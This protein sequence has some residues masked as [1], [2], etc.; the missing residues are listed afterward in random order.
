MSDSYYRSTDWRL[1]RKIIKARDPLCVAPGCGRATAHVDH[2]KPRSEGGSDDP[3]NLRGLCHSCHNSR[4]ARGNG[5]V[6]AIGCNADGTPRDI[7]DPW[8]AWGRPLP[9]KN[10]SAS[11]GSDRGGIAELSKFRNGRR[12]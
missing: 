7:N 5:P 12:H 1:L 9:V 4:S 8:Y 3:S 10:L 6:R 11:G 2:I